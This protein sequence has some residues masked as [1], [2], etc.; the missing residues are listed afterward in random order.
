MTTRTCG[1][2]RY[3]AVLF[4]FDMTLADSSGAIFHC[5]NLLAKEHGLREIPMAEVK[6][7][8]G[9]PIEDSWRAFWGEFRQSWLDYYR[10]NFRG[11]EI[12]RIKLY[13]DA[14][15]V[16][17]ELR[18]S[19]KKVGVASN[20][21]YASRAVEAVGLSPLLDVIIG[22]EDIERAKPEP[23]C[24]IKG[25]AALGIDLEYG[26]FV[27]DTDIDMKTAVAAGVRSIGVATGNFDKKGLLAA[28]ACIVVDDLGEL[29]RALKGI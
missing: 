11:D 5:T 9:L 27:G 25:F 20:R 26:V 3:D 17:K 15:S 7:A 16:L 13:P 24:L 21:R 23:D 22:L 19:G 6:A 4:D 1:G 12:T 28:G 2:K 29:P 8:I 10:S 18:E 14:V